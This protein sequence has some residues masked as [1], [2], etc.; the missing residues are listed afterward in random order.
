MSESNAMDVE[1]GQSDEEEYEDLL[2]YV[3]F[4]DFDQVNLLNEGTVVEFHDLA[5]ANPT[6]K[7]NDLNFVGNQEI[8]LGTQLFFQHTPDTVEFEGT[9]VNVV[10]FQLSSIGDS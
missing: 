7:I 5:T 3:E 4:P 10:K 6:C 1:H 2:V 9:S 8:N